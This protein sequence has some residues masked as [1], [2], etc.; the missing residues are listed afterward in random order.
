MKQ[1]ILKWWKELIGLIL[2][3]IIISLVISNQVKISKISKLESENNISRVLLDSLTVYKNKLGTITKE[4]QVYNVKYSQLQKAYNRLDEN[5]KQLV[6]KINILEKKNKLIEATNIHQEAV[7][8]DLLNTKPI[9]DDVK[10]TLTFIDSTK[11]LQY[12]FLV[13]PKEQSLLIQNLKLPNELYISH[14]FTKEGISVKVTNSND[15]Y[16]KTNDI[17]SYIIPLNKQKFKLK[18]Y[19]VVGGIGIT[20]GIVGTI[21][22]L[23]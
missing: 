15:A 22:L 20:A 3:V 18:P 12:N 7:I 2:L 23:K 5:S 9:V 13:N 11:F 21:F 1:F 19:L 17:N 16:F 8:K 10:G 6:N 4:K 14:S